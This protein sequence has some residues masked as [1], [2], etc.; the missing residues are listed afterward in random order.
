MGIG[1]RRIMGSVFVL[2]GSLYA[3]PG[4][5][6]N[7]GE[8]MKKRIV[9]ILLIAVF[10]L[11]LVMTSD[12]AE[13]E[14]QAVQHR[15]L[16][17]AIGAKRV[18]IMSE[19]GEIEWEYPAEPCTDAWQLDNGNILMSFTGKERGA[20]E[21]TPD[22]KVAWEY[23]TSSEVWSCQRLP[24]GNTLVAESSARRLVE[25]DRKGKVV[26]TVPIKSAGNSHMGMRHA[27]QLPNGNYLIGLLTDKAV[28]EYDSSGKKI[29]EIEVPDMG[30][31]MVR[32]D[33]G[34]TLIGYKR[35]VI[36]VDS[37]DN[38]VWH[39]T[40]KDLPDL[41]LQWICCVQR[42]PNGNTIVGNWF[43]HK[44]RTDTPPFFEVTP[45]KKV[46]WKAAM[47]K[48]M[49]DPCSIQILDVKDTSLR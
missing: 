36:E 40:Q 28:H 24:N 7:R 44:R 34:N 12:G 49:I 14:T 11:P 5:Q 26:K 25:V 3:E 9:N 10:L 21:V 19:A 17:S 13:P 6:L 4:Q 42:L 22:K 23:I 32:L 18:F 39:L 30:F 1:P 33:N 47:H 20:R 48:R 15:Y 35:G 43:A 41:K 31:S 8:E 29:R 38:V 2:L 37:K 46:V 16:C 45:D 27:R